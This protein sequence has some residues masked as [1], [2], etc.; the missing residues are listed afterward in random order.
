MRQ[1]KRFLIWV[2]VF[3]FLLALSPLFTAGANGITV[4]IDAP[5]E[6][7]DAGSEFV[8]RVSITE[9]TDLDSFQFD[10]SYDPSVI[11]VSDVTGGLIGSTSVPVD[12]WGFVP[13]GTQGT[14]R[15]LGNMAGFTGVTGSGYLAEIHFHVTGSAGSTSDMTFS[16]GTLVDTMAAYIPVAQWLGDSV[17]VYGTPTQP[18]IA[19]SPSSLSFTAIEARD[20]PSDQML[21]IWNSGVGTL[22][23]EVSE[24]VDWLSLSPS[25]GSST[26]GK[27]AVTVS[28][29]TSGMTAGDY[30]ATISISSPES[31]R[32]AL[33]ELHIS[34]SGE[35]PQEPPEEPPETPA[36][37]SASQLRI[38]PRWVEP[39]QQVEISIAISNT[40]QQTGSYTATLYI[41]DGPEDSRTVSISPAST[42]SVSFSV[43]KSEPGTYRVSVGGQE[44]QFTVVA[45][46][47]TLPGELEIVQIIAIAT[48]TIPLIVPIILVLVSMQ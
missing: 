32:T 16:D 48:G 13:S 15:V 3:S 31:T 36:E 35:P 11:E 2:V 47:T 21:E 1:C 7:V 29:D 10:I 20:N 9:V 43:T 38:S 27:D 24:A 25:G 46:G 4:R 34:V 40:G 12:M 6:Q 18:M 8:A 41:N 30:D 28:V 37:F 33:V 42:E 22:S 5:D 23:W 44:G 26:G 14:I 39:N 17:A 19:F 45:P